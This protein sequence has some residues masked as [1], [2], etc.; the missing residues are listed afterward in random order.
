MQQAVEQALG[1]IANCPVAVVAAGR[2][3]AGVHASQM[4]AHFDTHVVR[5]EYSWLR[6]TNSLLPPDVALRWI[7]PV[8]V[9]FHARFAAVSRRYQYVLYTSPSRSTL[10][11]LQATHVYDVLN[12]DAM[13][14]AAQLLVGSHDF[15]CFRA[16]ACQSK[17]PVRQVHHCQL[18]RVGDFIVLDIEANGFLHHMVRNIVGSLLVVGRGQQPPS[19]VSALLASKD[20]RLAA[21]TAP[22]DGL[23]FIHAG[24]PAGML[25]HRILPISPFGLYQPWL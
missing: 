3:D 10:T 16:A 24:Y 8:A 17:Q 9:D 7:Y 4:F 1:S 23:Y 22:P 19:W 14:Q 18:V 25:P 15:S 12:I 5:S 20:R 6:G 13:H 11:H 2:T 21:P